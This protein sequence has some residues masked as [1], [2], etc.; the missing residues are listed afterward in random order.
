MAKRPRPVEDASD[1][2]NAE[3]LPSKC[4]RVAND[5]NGRNARNGK[6]HKTPKVSTPARS[7]SSKRMWELTPEELDLEE[8]DFE[9]REFER[10]QGRIEQRRLN[11]SAG[12]VADGGVIEYL[13]L[14]QFMCH[15][16]LKLDF[17]PQTNFIIGGKSAVLSGLT[18]ALGGKATWTG[19]GSG[20]KSFIREGQ[21]AAEVTVGIRNRGEDAFRPEVFGET[22]NVTR[23]ILAQGA[24]TYKL[25]DSNGKVVSRKRADMTAMCDHLNIQ[26]DNPLTVLTQDAARQFLSSSHPRHKYEFFMKATLL[27]QLAHEYELIDEKIAQ[28]QRFAEGGRETLADLE[29]KRD[30]ANARYAQAE[31][32]RDMEGKKEQLGAELAWAHVA[33]KQTELNEI[34]QKLS[35]AQAHL[36]RVDHKLERLRLRHNLAEAA[37]RAAESDLPDQEE[38]AALEEEKVRLNDEAKRIT[39]EI[40]EYK[41]EQNHMNA[42]LTSH[43]NRIADLQGK[44]DADARK[45]QAESQ[46]T[47]SASQALINACKAELSAADDHLDEARAALEDYKASMDEAETRLQE[48]QG[49]ARK[50]RVQLK[51]LDEGVAR[52]QAQ[53]L[54]GLAAY[55]SN[56]KSVIQAIRDEKWAGKSAPIGPLG[57]FV[58]LKDKR[59]APPLKSMLGNTMMSFAVSDARDRAKLKAILNKT[60]NSRTSIIIAPI[61]IFD[62]S[63]GEPAED[64]L[65]ILRVLNISNAWALRV[66]INSHGIERTGLA[67]TRVEAETLLTK[68]GLSF[69]IAADDMLSVRSWADGGRYTQT[70][71]I[72]PKN[73]PRRTLFAGND[74]P[75]EIRRMKEERVLVE[76]QYT[77]AANAVKDAESLL[78]DAPR[79]LQRLQQTQ[80]EAKRA[81]NRLQSQLRARVDQHA[82][83][84]PVTVAGFEQAKAEEEA[85]KASVLQQFTD[86]VQRVGEKRAELR[87]LAARIGEIQQELEIQDAERTD[88]KESVLTATEAFM[89]AEKHVAAWEDKREEAQEAVNT[90][91]DAVQLRDEELATWTEK[92]QEISPRIENPRSVRAIEA[93]MQS[94]VNTLAQHQKE[95]RASLEEIS[96]ELSDAEAEYKRVKKFYKDLN[97]LLE[98]AEAALDERRDKWCM[99]RMYM[100][101]RCKMQFSYHLSCRAY[102]GKVSLKH[103]K[104]ELTLEV[105]T[106]DQASTSMKDTKALSGGEKSFSTICFLL[107]LWDCIGCPVRCLDEFDVFMDAVNRKVT[108]RMIMEAANEAHRKQYILISPQALNGVKLLPSVKVLRMSDPD[109]GQDEQ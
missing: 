98:A 97:K 102:Y 107:S 64:V 15:G 28:A 101:L 53:Q 61:D 91:L 26:V 14:K 81:Q 10:M 65:T 99:F 84:A 11:G 60:G 16:H 93:R 2:S 59:W 77:N 67:R 71:P 36:R 103:S 23:T 40:Q 75:G 58:D 21:S 12:A 43:N 19:R 37:V 34:N 29:Q 20:L 66:F 17:G 80:R 57:L 56:I 7:Q 87:P 106:E 6:T 4:V 33:A 54:N 70:V 42:D 8:E 30:A 1:A 92:A 85:R 90:L 31:R 105:R 50:W 5:D 52:C 95:Q 63:G 89:K 108:M 82:L 76:K 32:A 83:L 24:S 38:R 72:V 49:D 79:H 13:E 69:A 78:S 47:L 86:L 100:S 27:T 104:R 39:R 46:A 73:D 96:R 9:R 94:L 68:S 41:T 51:E 18:I 44:I 109:R 3:R 35:N 74:L 62:Y 55:G 22:I 88:I 45:L 48:S 25:Q